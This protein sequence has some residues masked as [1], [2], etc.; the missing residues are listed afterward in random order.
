MGVIEEFRRERRELRLAFFYDAK[1]VVEEA[2]AI[3]EGDLLK[4][5]KR[6]IRM[7]AKK[8]LF[9]LCYMNNM[10][11]KYIK[12]LLDNEGYHP[13]RETITEGI[14]SIEHKMATENYYHELIYDLY[15]KCASLESGKKL[16]EH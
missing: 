1:R 9:F 2:F 6:P 5:S 13:K 12:E 14:S 11:I 4:P 8:T 15:S 3:N 7:D 16:A 10:P